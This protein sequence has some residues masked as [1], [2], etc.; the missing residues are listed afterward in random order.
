MDQIVPSILLNMQIREEGQPS[1]MVPDENDPT[2]LAEMILKDLV[3]RA[4][5][6]NISACTQPILGYENSSSSS[7]RDASAFSSHFDNHAKWIPVDFPKYVFALVMNSIR[8]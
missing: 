4:H 8:V 3:F 6:N 5:S 2:N 1:T 7:S